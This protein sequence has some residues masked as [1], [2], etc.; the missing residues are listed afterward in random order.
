[1][2]EK[3]MFKVSMHKSCGKESLPIFSELGGYL[4]N[5]C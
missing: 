5:T 2:N 1:M 4:N 3:Y